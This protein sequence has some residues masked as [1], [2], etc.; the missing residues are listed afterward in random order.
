MSCLTSLAWPRGPVADMVE[1]DRQF[2]M[3]Y[4][5]EAFIDV[6]H[7]ELLPNERAL[8]INVANFLASH[9]IYWLNN[10]KD[11]QAWLKNVHSEQR[12][13]IL[14]GLVDHDVILVFGTDIASLNVIRH[15]QDNREPSFR[16]A[17]CPLWFFDAWRRHFCSFL[18]QIHKR[19][20]GHGR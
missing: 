15:L 19:L 8:W 9:S 1:F 11:V 2:N 13:L 6:S 14:N 18:Y 20:E 4:L 5:P 7:A 16:V 17:G 12:R 10:R 3:S